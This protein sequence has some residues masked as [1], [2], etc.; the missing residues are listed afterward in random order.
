[1]SMTPEDDLH[2][3]HQH[4]LG[5]GRHVQRCPRSDLQSLLLE[6]HY[7]GK[8]G[9]GIRLC[10]YLPRRST[11]ASRTRRRE[12]RHLD[13]R[14]FV[15][16]EDAHHVEHKGHDRRLARQVDSRPPPNKRFK[17]SPEGAFQAGP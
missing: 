12:H 4:H 16:R 1:M 3:L 13:D 5:L 14:P 17:A 11:R 6:L 9:S 7:A 15:R 8:Q 10:K 2:R